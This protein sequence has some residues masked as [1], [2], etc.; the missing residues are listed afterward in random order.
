MHTDLR[1]EVGMV[2]S[3][4]QFEATDVWRMTV[5]KGCTKAIYM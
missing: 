1:D 2:V 5:V 4:R 3:F